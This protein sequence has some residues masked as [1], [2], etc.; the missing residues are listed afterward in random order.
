MAANEDFD[1][2]LGDITT[3]INIIQYQV[4][5]NLDTL[6]KSPP[7]PKLLDQLVK[8][9]TMRA[10]TKLKNAHMILLKYRKDNH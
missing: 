6:A 7:D 8:G 2:A 4:L 9:P 5:N 1:N 10:L 3:Q